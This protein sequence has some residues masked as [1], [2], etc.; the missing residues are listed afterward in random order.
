MAESLHLA[1]AESGKSE[2]YNVLLP[3]LESLLAAE[4]DLT[5]NLANV[6]AA[7]KQAFGFFWIGFYIVRAE[8]LVLGPF[9]GPLACTRISYGKGVCGT[10]WKEGR[11][12]LVPDVEQFPGHIACSSQSKSEIVVPVFANDRVVAVI[13]ADS[14][15]LADFDECDAEGLQQVARLV[16]RLFTQSVR[17]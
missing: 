11:T 8:E 5:A 14:D 13:D 9:Q 2:R 17:S 16:S 1:P 10:A 4:S 15:V 3:Q 12:L 6:A 7:L